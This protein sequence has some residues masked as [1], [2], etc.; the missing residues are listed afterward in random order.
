MATSPDLQGDGVP[1]V[2]WKASMPTA[3]ESLGTHVHWTSRSPTD[4]G[5]APPTR[6]KAG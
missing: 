2:S 1:T 4:G 5:N 3:G 6:R